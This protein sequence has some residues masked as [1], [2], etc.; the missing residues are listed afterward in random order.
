MS[1]SVVSPGRLP[2]RLSACGV[3]LSTALSFHYLCSWSVLLSVGDVD[4]LWVFLAVLCS[5]QVA[6]FSNSEWFSVVSLYS[7]MVDSALSTLHLDWLAD[8]GRSTLPLSY[9]L[10]LLA[11]ESLGRSCFD[12]RLLPLFGILFFGFSQSGSCDVGFA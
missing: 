2:G 1:E 10:S 11:C 6:L 5:V 9:S 4:F 8:S 7:D 12:L 3:A